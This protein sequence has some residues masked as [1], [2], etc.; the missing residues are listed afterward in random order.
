[1]FYIININETIINK[2]FKRQSIP[3][4]VSMI[5]NLF[6]FTVKIF[7]F[8]KSKYVFCSCFFKLSRAGRW[9]SPPPPD[10]R[11]CPDF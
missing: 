5:Q 3:Y 1:M 10:V 2:I 9:V 8:H 11:V 7:L 6:Y 4:N